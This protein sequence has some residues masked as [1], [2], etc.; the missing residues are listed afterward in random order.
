MPIQRCLPLLLLS[1]ESS[2]SSHRS[3]AT[4]GCGDP[5]G[6]SDDPASSSS[7]S[8]SEDDSEDDCKDEGDG[9]SE[10]C[11]NGDSSD[12]A[13]GE[14]GSSDDESGSDDDNNDSKRPSAQ[15]KHQNI[16]RHIP[17]ARR[18][19]TVTPKGDRSRS[20][21]PVQGNRVQNDSSDKKV[22]KK[23]CRSPAATSVIKE[24]IPSTKKAVQR[25]KKKEQKK[26]TSTRIT[27][28]DLV[29]KIRTECRSDLGVATGAA[30]GAAGA[31]AAADDDK[32][33]Q[34]RLKLN[35]RAVQD[36]A[37]VMARWLEGP[38]VNMEALTPTADLRTC[39]SRI[40]SCHRGLRRLDA[41]MLKGRAELGYFILTAQNL[42]E[43]Q[44]G[45]MGYGDR[46]F[47]AF[48]RTEYKMAE[49][50]IAVHTNWTVLVMRYPRLCLLRC[51]WTAVRGY[52]TNNV[53]AEAV[54]RSRLD[55]VP[56]A[57]VH[58]MLIACHNRRRLASNKTRKQ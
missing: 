40:S 24:K 16:G 18:D 13:L 51:S 43:M 57:D 31:A 33:Q 55:E 23:R 32:I 14:S 20:D 15:E 42:W 11:T 9:Q 17:C 2:V 12:D 28:A 4:S 5:S 49:S 53:L 1:I 34:F 56:I 46:N 21:R 19:S 41:G 37:A 22:S 10:S 26:P 36:N 29:D 27:V 39:L 38:L 25:Q 50:S 3:I 54:Q 30:A 7:P 58:Q 6:E 44:K 35:A 8:N 52:M 47:S 45:G 48:M